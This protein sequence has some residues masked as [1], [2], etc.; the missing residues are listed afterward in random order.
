MPNEIF[1]LLRKFGDFSAAY[2]TLQPD[3]EYYVEPDLGY[4][5]FKRIPR[6]FSRIDSILVLANPVVS[7]ADRYGLLQRFLH[8]YPQAAFFQIDTEVALMLSSLGRYVNEFGVDTDLYLPYSL[9]GGKRADIRLLYNRARASG[10]QVVELT[11]AQRADYGIQDDTIIELC[12][13]WIRSRPA[14]RREFSFLS[15]RYNYRDEP[16]CRKFYALHYG[17]LVGL[18]VF[19]PIY[20]AGRI[21][22]YAE[23]I[24]RTNHAAPKGTRDYLLL[25]AMEKMAKEGVR[26]VSLGLSPLAEIAI[27]EKGTGELHRSWFTTLCFIAAY[28]GLDNIA[29]NFQGLS[30]KK[31]SFVKRPQPWEGKIEKRYCAFP[32]RFPVRELYRAYRATV[33]PPLPK[34]GQENIVRKPSYYRPILRNRYTV[35]GGTSTRSERFK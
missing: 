23:V 14:K 34:P 6:K 12:N 1:T 10:V 15:R 29:F 3:L 20:K 32:T 35:S 4:V 7:A 31:G 13:E 18:V 16:D 30:F 26:F 8:I 22:A 5:A 11:R 21:N 28:H 9:A 17:K 25:T 33:L 27:R 24:A 19:D 2:H